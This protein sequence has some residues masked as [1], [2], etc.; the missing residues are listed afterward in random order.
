[1]GL[2]RIESLAGVDG[3]DELMSMITVNKDKT[4]Q[5]ERRGEKCGKDLKTSGC[6]LAKVSR[7]NT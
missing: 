6:Q 1:M 5:V 3:G 2:K 4:R 7:L